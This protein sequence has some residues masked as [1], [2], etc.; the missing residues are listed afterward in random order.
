MEFLNRMSELNERSSWFEAETDGFSA[1]VV[2]A[3]AEGR[4]TDL[5][6]E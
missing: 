3:Q 5:H 2:S 1:V 6:P 4:K